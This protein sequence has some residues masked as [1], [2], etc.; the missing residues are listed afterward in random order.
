MIGDLACGQLEM[1]SPV[2]L[3]DVLY[4]DSCPTLANLTAGLRALFP[5]AQPGTT[6]LYVFTE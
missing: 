3:L 6:I 1:L 5:G 4:V 2:L